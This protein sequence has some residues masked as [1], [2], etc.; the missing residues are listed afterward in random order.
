MKNIIIFVLFINT[1]LF[2]QIKGN[3]KVETRTF[4]LEN[5]RDIKINL[6]A[7]ITI[8]YAAK[9]QMS[10]TTDANLFDNIDTEVLD[11][12]LNLTQLKWIQPS[13]K[14]IVKIGAPQL[15]RLETGTHETLN[16][17]NIDSEYLNL[18]APLGKIIASG[19]VN[20]L[21]LGIENGEIDASELMSKNVRANIWGY[22]KA[23]VFAEN[24]V[25]SIIKND[26]KLVLANNPKSLKG[27]T[28]RAIKNSLKNKT[29]ISWI[30]FKIKNNSLNR[31]NF[32]VVGP[33]ADGS[34]FSYGFP[35]MPQTTRKENWSVGTKVYKVNKLGLRKLVKKITADDE[36]E[37]VRLFDK[38]TK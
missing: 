34:K 16:I 36:G 21:N 32:F 2:A 17:I 10:I 30:R 33:K 35:M 11:G 19:K 27:D 29:D 12:K 38:N 20:Q 13:S 37:V 8:D 3:K 23:T 18:M 4:T 6:Y 14:I 28:K 26:G 22:G 9:E 31:H 15:E 25:Y 7:K 5:L 24:E 1:A